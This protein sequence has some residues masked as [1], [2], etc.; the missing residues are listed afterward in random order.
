MK[1]IKTIKTRMKQV[2][3]L[4]VSVCIFLTALPIMF[5][6]LADTT[7]PQLS[8]KCE[9]VIDILGI[10]G[11][12]GDDTTDLRTSTSIKFS[13]SKDLSSADVF[14]L[15]VYIE[16]I[17]ALN[18]AVSNSQYVQFGFSSSSRRATSN[19]ADINIS[20]QLTASGW[21]HIEIL[22]SD[23][24]EVNINWSKIY[25]VYMKFADESGI[26]PSVLSNMSVKMRNI[27]ESV[28]IPEMSGDNQIVFDSAVI[29][30]LAENADSSLSDI[31]DKFKATFESSDLSKFDFIEL[32][33]YISDMDY[34]SSFI[35]DKKLAFVLSSEKGDASY[36]FKGAF[37]SN[38]IKGWHTIKLPL[39]GFIAE[40][41]FDIT[42]VNTFKV[43][44]SGNT[45]KIGDIYSLG[46]GIANIR[47]LQLTELDKSPV[48]GSVKETYADS[49][50]ITVFG[51]TYSD[52]N[53]NYKS[54]FSALSDSEN[55]E[56][57]LYIVDYNKFKNSFLFDK[58]NNP[59]AASLDF[60]IAKGENTYVWSN[61]Q[62]KVIS[63]GWNH[64][65]LPIENGVNNGFDKNAKFET[66]SFNIS[67]VDAAVKNSNFGDFLVADNIASTIGEANSGEIKFEENL[68]L[69]EGK[70]DLIKESFDSSKI[71]ENDITPSMD[72]TNTQYIEFDIYIQNFNSFKNIMNENGVG[73][74]CLRLS[75]AIGDSLSTG[76]T[77]Q[78]KNEGWNHVIIP[79][80]RFINGTVSGNFD[81]TKV[82]AW[83]L[84][85][86]GS[87]STEILKNQ[88][89]SIK[90]I[91]SCF[92]IDPQP[93]EDAVV[94]LSENGVSGKY[95]EEYSSIVDSS[96][97]SLDEPMD[98]SKIGQI[99]FDFFVDDLEMVKKMFNECS[100]PFSF[101]IGT[102]TDKSEKIGLYS[103]EEQIISD[104]WNHIVLDTLNYIQADK[105]SKVELN[106]IYHIFLTFG[107][108]ISVNNFGDEPFKIKNIVATYAEYNKIPQLPAEYDTTMLNEGF[109]A[110]YGENISLQFSMVSSLNKAVVHKVEP[111]DMTKADYFEFDIYVSDVEKLK[112]YDKYSL[113]VSLYT[114]ADGAPGKR[115]DYAFIDQV[116]HEGWNHIVVKKTSA[117]SR[118]AADSYPY[119]LDWKNVC[120][121]SLMTYSSGIPQTDG[122]GFAVIANVCGVIGEESI[123][124]E[125]PDNILEEIDE[126]SYDTLGEYFGYIV[127][128]IYAQGIG[129]YDFSKGHTIEF[130][131]FVSDFDALKKAFETERGRQFALVF[132]SV[133]LK[134]FD[135]YNKPR[136]YYS[137]HCDLTDKITK[138]GWNHI[139]IGKTEFTQLAGN[140]D[141]SN[142]TSYMLRFGK[143]KFNKS[144]PE[145]VN[146]S[147][148]VYIKI[149]NVCNTGIISDVPYDEKQPAKPDKE[150][151]YINDAE[152]LVDDNGSWNPSEVYSDE[153]YK[154][155]NGHSVLRKVS[156]E[157]A[158]EFSRMFY[159]FDYSADLSDIK[160]L[161]LDLFVDLPQ[162]IQKSG[163]K[164]EIGLSS[165]RSLEGNYTWNIDTSTLKE[166]WNTV[167]FDISKAKKS[168]NVSLN[169]IRTIFLRFTELNLSSEEFEVIV[170]GVDNLRYISN[171]GNTTLKINNPDEDFDYI[172]DEDFD[173][174]IS[175]DTYEEILEVDKEIITSEPKTFLQNETVHKTATN[176]ILATIIL[177]AEFA[178]LTAASI[179]TFVILKKKKK[180]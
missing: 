41:K 56:F 159:L 107:E 160:M 108:E 171:N 150:A 10:D 131:L 174:D 62:N 11:N 119:V 36:E 60:S 169:E 43:D 82:S 7:E 30:N 156:Y 63:S 93:S 84:F 89:V 90:N 98:L 146:P 75:S 104:G 173:I 32:D 52:F 35:S 94:V 99:E 110:L 12:F 117:K 161:N 28:I 9:T 177:C 120:A 71:F 76:I 69:S 109:S 147:P 163:N 65:V 115:A 116:T 68:V 102:D 24:D 105:D 100:E 167:S 165:K 5:G 168:G 79:F 123:I 31:G 142:I 78:I 136:Q 101:A 124:P 140:M 23:F 25:F 59:I 27:C 111:L 153:N 88:I 14:E 132:S 74:I 42:D 113:Y 172:D 18:K 129:P 151:V 40:S 19:H 45:N 87:S 128:R 1:T 58:D 137:V 22:R 29:G 33:M 3:C 106:K 13:A 80:S 158:P 67:G 176:Y 83:E 114:A 149:A 112:A 54:S 64:I 121:V 15:D 127:D 164:L 97:I 139:K 61:I 155:E 118:G 46:F 21:N 70:T 66:L 144:D 47:V 103:I 145:E 48:Y 44:I 50:I 178:V 95:G 122:T 138:S 179:I 92:V 170:I 91:T 17:E 2:L 77:Y 180:I 16:D 175:D 154:T 148:D 39:F 34:F 4:V 53:C 141:W 81:I 6:V 125:K 49:K 135:Q 8:S 130:D 133:P 38:T 166:G 55:I 51:E 96:M 26:L 37:L 162:F 152:N 85:F 72:F 143:S 126:I 20:S 134:L 73:D 86:N 57:D 157:T